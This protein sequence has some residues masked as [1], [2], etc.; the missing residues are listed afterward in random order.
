MCHLKPDKICQGTEL[1]PEVLRRELKG[2][3]IPAYWSNKSALFP[4]VSTHIFLVSY[5]NVVM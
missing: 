5:L 3:D 1:H 2:H 4:G